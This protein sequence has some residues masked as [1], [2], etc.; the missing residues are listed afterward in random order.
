MLGSTAAARELPRVCVSIVL[1]L[2]HGRPMG[3]AS[4]K[5]LKSLDVSVSSLALALHHHAIPSEIPTEECETTEKYNLQ[6]SELSRRLEETII[7]LC[8]NWL[9]SALDPYPYVLEMTPYSHCGTQVQIRR[10]KETE[11]LGLTLTLMTLLPTMK[12][13]QDIFALT[14]K[15]LFTVKAV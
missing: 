2:C 9:Q 15:P 8:D 10:G 5:F 1:T 12:L 4:S 11:L 6:V 3:T 14:L 7:L 13:Q